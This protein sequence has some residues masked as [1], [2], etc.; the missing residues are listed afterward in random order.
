MDAAWAST[1]L[2]ML[3]DIFGHSRHPFHHFSKNNE[4]VKNI[5]HVINLVWP[6]TDHEI[7]WSDAACPKVRGILSCFYTP[8]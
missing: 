2:P 7:Q 4:A 5:Q 3:Y 6:G 1:F 8:L